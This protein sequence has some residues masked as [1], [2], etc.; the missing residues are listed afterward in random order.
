MLSTNLYHRL[1]VDLNHLMEPLQKLNEGEVKKVAH[2]SLIVSGFST[3]FCWAFMNNIWRL[4][5]N[6]NIVNWNEIKVAWKFH[7]SCSNISLQP[8]Q[9]LR[10]TENSNV[11]V[12]QPF[13]NVW[14]NLQSIREINR[15]DNNFTMILFLCEYMYMHAQA[16]DHVMCT[17]KHI[18]S[19]GG[20]KWGKR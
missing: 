2:L 9:I 16:W 15:D 14:I 19:G 17:Y 20:R 5:R 1:T 13:S 6:T 12:L 8:L 3:H 4:K 11:Q 18:G 10:L 7:H